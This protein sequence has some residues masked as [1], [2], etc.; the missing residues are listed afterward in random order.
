[1]GF[2]QTVADPEIWNRGGWRVARPRERLCAPSPFFTNLCRNNAFCVKFY[3][4][5][6]KYL[7]NREEAKKSSRSS[8]HITFGVQVNL[9][10]RVTVKIIQCDWS[11]L[12][13]CLRDK[14]QQFSLTHSMRYNI[15]LKTD[16]PCI[17]WS[18]QKLSSTSRSYSR[19]AE[20]HKIHLFAHAKRIRNK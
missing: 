19:I 1:M 9:K 10:Y 14:N 2:I 17:L 8:T 3:L 15:A 5:I 7:V 13:H 4:V 12:Q 18:K 16:R 6:K 11:S 20:Q